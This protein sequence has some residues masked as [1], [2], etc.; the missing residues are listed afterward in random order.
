MGGDSV[1]PLGRN[2]LAALVGVK[3]A[4][5]L[6]TL[7]IEFEHNPI[8]T[9]GAMTLTNAAR[10]GRQL[11]QGQLTFGFHGTDIDQN[12]LRHNF[13]RPTTDETP[14][15]DPSFSARYTLL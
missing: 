5:R 14:A 11:P 4:P 15:M 13:R 6:H 7:H 9:L 12:Y 8:Q 3:N 2:A 10:G 1:N